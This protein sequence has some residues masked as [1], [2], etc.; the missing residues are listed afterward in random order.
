M[1]IT[2]EAIYQ[3]FFHG[4]AYQVLE[5]AGIDGNQAVGLMSEILP[6]ATSPDDVASLIAPRLVELCFQ[7][8]ALWSSETRGAMA[9]PLGFDVLE[10]YCQE[11]DGAGR[12]LYAVASTDSAGE[13]FDAA[14]VDDKGTVYLRL[15]GYRTV[16]RPGA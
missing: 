13:V 8:I 16:S 15:L 12:R 2:A 4:P 10:V 9:L 14:V 5:R 6:P 3:Q 7:T 11:A 1:P